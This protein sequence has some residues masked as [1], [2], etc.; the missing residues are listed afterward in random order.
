VFPRRLST[1]DLSVIQRAY[2][3]HC[4]TQTQSSFVHT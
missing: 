1:C 3:P 2:E 4:P